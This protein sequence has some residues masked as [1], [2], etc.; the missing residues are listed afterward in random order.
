MVTF[1]FELEALKLLKKKFEPCKAV[2]T[3]FERLTRAPPEE[4]H[5]AAREV[6]S[7]EEKEEEAGQAW[8]GEGEGEGLMRENGQAGKDPE[9]IG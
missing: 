6:G 5:Q 9:W 8:E 2:G 3:I 4:E 1:R 7:V